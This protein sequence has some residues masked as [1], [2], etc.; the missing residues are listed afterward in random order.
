MEWKIG[1]A[2][3]WIVGGKGGM[4]KRKEGKE[5]E[6]ERII[7]AGISTVQASLR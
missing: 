7:T 5:R 2:L 3:L 4:G 6:E 1:F